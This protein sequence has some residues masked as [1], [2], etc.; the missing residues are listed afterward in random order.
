MA[1]PTG[2]ACNLRCDYCF[3]LEKRRLYPGERLRMSDEVL[4]AYIRQYLQAQGGD[5]TIIAWQ[6]GEPTMMGLDFFRRSVELAR[7]Y[8]EPGTAVEH[9]I[10][11]N[12]ILIDEEWCDFFRENGF[13]VGLS[14]DGPR[15][16]HDRYRH[17][18]EGGPTFDRVMTAADLMKERGVDF[19]VLCSVHAASAPHPLEIYRFF[20]R[21]LGVRWIQFIPIVERVN[22]D[23]TTLLQEGDTVT[24]RSVDPAAWGRFL[25]GVFDEWLPR[26]VGEVHVNFFECAFAA[27]VGAPGPACILCETCGDALVL[28]HNGDLYSCDHFVE[29]SHLL[30]N[31]METP[32]S[33]LAASPAQRTFGDA[34][35]DGL[36]SRC[37]DCEVLFACRGECLKNR[38]VST[39]EGEPGLNYL[40]EGY[41]DFFEHVS[42]AMGAM[43]RLYGSGR[44]PGE[45]VELF[46]RAGRN[47]PCPCSSGKKFKVCH[48]RG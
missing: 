12:G 24:D 48:G 40:C 20:T 31:I 33:E 38:F 3:F 29:P 41:R 46:S 14:L 35:R 43:A 45:I 30:G 22:E 32:M 1:K 21:E 19:N 28:E 39:P 2:A 37:R 25:T 36:P 9:T 5:G 15:E 47:D 18:P 13:L 23:G 7:R 10:Q 6:G 27:T 11:T 42:P 44:S 34:K 17:D 16:M 4:E 8:A 26:D